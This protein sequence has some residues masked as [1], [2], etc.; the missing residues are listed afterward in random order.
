M[1][2]IEILIGIYYNIVLS[3]GG[4]EFRTYKVPCQLDGQA[5]STK[6]I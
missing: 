1:I 3:K 5:L 2:K 4:F 6:T